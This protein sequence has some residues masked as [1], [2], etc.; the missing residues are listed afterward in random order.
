MTAAGVAND[1]MVGILIAILGFIVTVFWLICSRQNWK[2]IKNL[3]IKHLADKKHDPVEEVVQQSLFKH[4]WRRPTDLIAKPLPGVFLIIWIVII[5]V[6][7]WRLVSP[8]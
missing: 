2:V 4:G 5:I 3:T 7:I 1:P 6:Y 8:K